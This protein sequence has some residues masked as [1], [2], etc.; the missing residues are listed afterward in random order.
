[1]PHKATYSRFKDIQGLC[2]DKDYKQQQGSCV[3]LKGLRNTDQHWRYYLVKPAFSGSVNLS[4]IF[5]EG[6]DNRVN[7]FGVLIKWSFE[8]RVLK[9]GIEH[10]EIHTFPV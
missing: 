10:V 9:L 8:H 5:W 4:V 1:M 7:S 2:H 3:D 6:I